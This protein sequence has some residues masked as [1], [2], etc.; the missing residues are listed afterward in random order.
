MGE[1]GERR[2]GGGEG[3]LIG[4]AAAG[5]TR[6]HQGPSHRVVGPGRPGTASQPASQ[7]VSQPVTTVKGVCTGNLGSSH[8]LELIYTQLHTLEG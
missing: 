4:P 1:G 2:R 8:R 7:P 6:L 5:K 3:S